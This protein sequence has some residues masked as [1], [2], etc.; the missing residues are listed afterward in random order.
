MFIADC[1]KKGDSTA[2][3]VAEAAER[4]ISAM[5]ALGWFDSVVARAR[6]VP[7]PVPYNAVTMANV[8]SPEHRYLAYRAAAE[9]LVLLKNARAFLPLSFKKGERVVLVGPGATFTGT[10]T[11]SYLG[12]FVVPASPENGLPPPHCS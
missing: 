5:M 7:D 6:G 4:T 8:S 12:V 3:R 2:A 10:S 9:S 11:S 1:V